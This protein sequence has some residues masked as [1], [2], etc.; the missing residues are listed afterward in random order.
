MD[1]STRCW[2]T[3]NPL[4]AKYHDEE[5]GVPLHDDTKLF[6]F[7]TLEAF[8]AGLTWELVL[9][10]REALKRAFDGFDP[11]IISKYTEADI[12]RLMASPNMIRNKAKIN[13]TLNNAKKVIAIKREFGSFDTY[14]WQFVGN[15]TIDNSL[16]DFSEMPSQSEESRK[17]SEDLKKR[18]F[19]FVGPTICYAL[20]QAVGMVNDH[21]ISCSQFRKNVI[22]NSQDE[23]T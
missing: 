15:R 7:L 3:K 16:K 13:A 21:L 22:K 8:Q 11:L 2:K 10:R 4:L 19:K 23:H 5:W 17:M 20:M 18:G 12:E 6:E 14:L 1:D 9:N